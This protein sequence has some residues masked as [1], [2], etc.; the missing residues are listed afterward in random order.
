MQNSGILLLFGKFGKN[1]KIPFFSFFPFLSFFS[2]FF[3]L[4]KT[5]SKSKHGFFSFF[6]QKMAIFK[7][8]EKWQNSGFLD[9]QEFA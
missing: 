7:K 5:G 3:I 9:F 1:Q 2:I 4:K 8:A 6:G